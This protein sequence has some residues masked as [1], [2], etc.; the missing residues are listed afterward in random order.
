MSSQYKTVA[1]YTLGCKLNFSETSTIS[2][3]FSNDWFKKFDNDVTT[4]LGSL[5]IYMA[6]NELFK[7]VNGYLLFILNR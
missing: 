3:D 2:K 7:S 6:P 1:F 5:T 4:F